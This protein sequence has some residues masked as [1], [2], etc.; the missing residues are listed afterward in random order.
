MKPFT[1][2]ILALSFLSSCAVQTPNPL[3]K[4]IQAQSQYKQNIGSYTIDGPGDQMSRDLS[5]DLKSGKNQD[6]KIDR[7]GNLKLKSSPSRGEFT[8]AAIKSPFSFTALTLGWDAQ[9]PVKVM[10]RT[11][12]DKKK[13]HQWRSLKSESDL[14]IQEPQNWVQYRV[15]ILSPQA[16]FEGLELQFG[17]QRNIQR[18]LNQTPEIPKPNI[19][20]RE[21]WGAL[22][23]KDEYSPHTPDG[24]VIH[25]TW[26]PRQENYKGAASIQGIQ[27]YHMKTKK[28]ND[29]GYHFLIGPDGLIFQGRPETVIGAHSSP[30]TGKIGI[31]VI[32]DY[33]T[34]QDPFTPKIRASLVDLMTWLTATYKINTDN[35][36]GHRDFSPKS[37]PGDEVYQHLD[38]FKSEIKSRL[39]IIDQFMRPLL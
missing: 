21:E 39:G 14:L 3:T 24:I 18:H 5:Q 17:R 11:S 15:Q 30:N 16:Q 12:P 33:D 7:Q 37:C 32:G 23:P 28:W 2:A 20:S 36:F 34:D 38:N 27:R 29:I 10:M 1:Q 19:I 13:W 6:L 22:S 8:S 9:G 35:F 4:K 31:C 26:K 25:H